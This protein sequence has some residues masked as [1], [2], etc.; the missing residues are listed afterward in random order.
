MKTSIKWIF[1]FSVL[2]LLAFVTSDVQ[3]FAPKREYYEIKVYHFRDKAQEE[4]LDNYFKNAYL[5]ALHRRGIKAVGVFKAINNDTAADKR[6]YLLI[7]YKSLDQFKK[8]Q[9]K[10]VNDA[11]L[12]T[13]G[14]DYYN[15]ASNNPAFTRI[16]SILLYAFPDHPSMKQ[17][18]LSGPRSERVYE[19]RNYESASERLHRSKVKMFNEGGEVRIF[20]RL[21]FNA[22][23]Y[24][25]VLA[26][27]RM[28]NLMYMTTFENRQSRDEHWRSFSN[29]PEWKKVSPLEEYKGNVSR[30]EQI[31]LRPTE[32][33]DY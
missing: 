33:S 15:A 3:A 21:G 27:S 30:N 31:F 14:S 32:Y 22:V 13:A 18:G 29:D 26:G 9:D 12:Q 2:L 4:R 23:F 17:P 5:P 16:E 25:A 1:P 7:P 19:L 28:P 20:N 11:A 6:I 24:A 8:T 10:L